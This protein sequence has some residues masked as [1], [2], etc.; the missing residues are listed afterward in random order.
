M[1]ENLKISCPFY[2]V[3]LNTCVG[4]KNYKDFFRVM[5]SI[6]AMQLF[7]TGISAWL[8]VDITLGGPTEGRADEWLGRSG[9]AVPVAAVLLFFVVF[10]LISLVLLAQ[11]ISFHIHLQKKRITTYQYIVQDGQRR[12]EKAKLQM[13][14]DN[15]RESE[16]ARARDEGLSWYA[17]RLNAGEKFRQW[18]CCG[19][20]DPLEM[21]QPAPEPDPSA[22]FSV[23]LGGG[24][25]GGGTAT[26]TGTAEQP[27]LSGVDGD[28]DVDEDTGEIVMIQNVDSLSSSAA[29]EEN[30][31][32]TGTTTD[33]TSAAS[34][35]SNSGVAFRPPSS[36][37]L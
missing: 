14:L 15:Q 2:L 9:M 13:D 32:E 34:N 33:G 8:A 7:H 26:T 4:A 30:R 1:W 19:C 24:G 16:L 12:R 21:P 11:L 35:H 25:G 20:L 3:G 22:G 5:L 27:N 23:A 36:N 17:F 28:G 29:A 37:G 18:G 6:S 31:D 10:D